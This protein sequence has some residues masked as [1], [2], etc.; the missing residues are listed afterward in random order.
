MREDLNGCQVTEREEV[1]L[2]GHIRIGVD[3]IPLDCVADFDVGPI[4]RLMML[5]FRIELNNYFIWLN[6]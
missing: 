3:I 5:F 4:K 1:T 6:F 2:V